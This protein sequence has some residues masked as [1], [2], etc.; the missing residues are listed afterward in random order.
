MSVGVGWLV[1]WQVLVAEGGSS[2]MISERK[3]G[4]GRKEVEVV[5]IRVDKKE[6]LGSDEISSL[7]SKRY[8]P[9]YAS[10][11]SIHGFG[12]FF[13][14]VFLSSQLSSQSTRK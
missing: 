12:Q 1:D 6:G 11:M 9:I 5:I 8:S 7:S 14:P 4:K 3:R 13:L 2:V 10:Q